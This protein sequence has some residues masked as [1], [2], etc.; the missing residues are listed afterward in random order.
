MQ[1]SV[2]KKGF[3]R[4]YNWFLEWSLIILLAA[5]V[6]VIMYYSSQTAE[7]SGALSRM[8][9]NKLNW[10]PKSIPR[11][12]SSLGSSGITLHFIVRKIAHIYNFFVIGCILYVMKKT[13]SGSKHIDY[14]WSFFGLV[15]GVMDECLQ[16][17]VRGRSGQVTDVCVDFTGVLLGYIF[18][19]LLYRKICLKRC[20]QWKRIKRK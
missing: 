15:I 9:M 11:E 10:I 5:Q 20:G 16:L 7:Q 3:S 4:E 1:I 17:F 12:K 18:V 2:Y 14:V 19:Y 13:F 6:A 8:I